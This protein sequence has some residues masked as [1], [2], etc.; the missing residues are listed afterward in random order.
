MPNF[1]KTYLIFSLLS[2][3]YLKN[4]SQNYF[5]ILN[6]YSEWHVTTCYFGCLTDKYYTI[7]DTLINGLHYTFLDKY[8]YNKNFVIREDTTTKKVY[9][10]LLAEP[11]TIKE[12]LLYNFSLQ[13]GDTMFITNPGSPFPKYAGNFLVDSI[14]LRPIINS[15]R[16]HFYLHSLDTVT[17]VTKNTIW[18]E[19]IGSLCLINTP[20]APPQINGA[21]QLGCFFHNNIHEYENLDSISNCVPVYPTSISE[22]P[23]KQTDIT[24]HQYFEK[25]LLYINY[26]LTDTPLS[27]KLYDL[28]GKSLFEYKGAIHQ[29]LVISLKAYAAGFLLLKIET[30][31]Q[32]SRSFKILNP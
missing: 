20:G 3:I 25:S 16:K 4:H 7:G 15:T 24:V 22:S 8:H 26:P 11:N 5:P 9:M 32:Q 17:S 28:T 23:N 10:R 13:V 1:K 19:G 12:Y 2:M 14:V 18:I 27:I 29:R 21:G 30:N 6:N 31:D